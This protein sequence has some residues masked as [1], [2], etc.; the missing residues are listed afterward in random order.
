MKKSNVS[1]NI[2]LAEITLRKYEKPYE[3]SKRELVKKLCLSV[4]L[5]QPGDS[6]DIVVDVFCVLLD[7]KEI[8]GNAI[9][10]KV[11]EYRKQ[12]NL[13]LKG[14]AGS[15]IRRQLKR[16]KDLFLV[17]KNGNVYRINE[18][19]KLKSLFEE[20]IENFYLK[21]IVSRVKE[22]FDHLDNLK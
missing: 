14:I 15:N 22:Y 9:V 2:P 10:E 6:R 20:K 5:L 3:M 21:S 7:N 12:S 13:D 18:N 1:K 11:I 16:L 17:E 19:E 4:G 8:D